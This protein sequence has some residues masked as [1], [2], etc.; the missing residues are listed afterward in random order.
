MTFGAKLRNVVLAAGLVLIPT[1]AMAADQVKIESK[2]GVANANKGEIVYSPSTSAKTDDT[3][4]AQVWYHNTENADS[5]KVANNL[6]VKIDLPQTAGKTQKLTGTV[7]A[8]NSNVVTNSPIVNLE[9]EQSRL[10]YVAGS[11]QWRHNKGTNEAPVW[12]T[13]SISDSVVNGGIVLEN[14]KPCFNFEGSVTIK[15]RVKTDMVTIKK[16][17]RVVGSKD[18][19]VSNTAKAGDTLEYLITFKNEGNT[20]LNALV[21]GDNL[22]AN[23]TYV[24][25][26]SKLINGT[27]P[28]GQKLTTD[29]VTKGGVEIGN[30]LP[31]AGGYVQF[32]AKINSDLTA[33]DHDLKNVAIVKANGLT[34][35]NYAHTIVHVAGKPTPTPV[36]PTVTP[37][38]PT[39]PVTPALPQTGVEGAAAGFMGTGALTYAGYFYR[40]SKKN[41]VSALR[42]VIK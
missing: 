35:E 11:A 19:T 31:G 20:T 24:A 14:E 10:E 22:P 13:E 9:L 4:A 38:T 33:G 16:E 26:S 39:T 36:T 41:L 42:N 15:M 27:Y 17:V 23:V 8:D 32:Q 25:G 28:N 5:G 40:K 1:T 30:Y 12:V 2:F 7:S 34:R 6:K 29:N 3:I 18:W 21:I 37:A